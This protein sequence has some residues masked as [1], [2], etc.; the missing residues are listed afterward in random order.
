MP[1]DYK[2][3]TIR[4][5]EEMTNEKYIKSIFYYVQ[6]PYNKEKLSAKE[7]SGG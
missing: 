3:E 6:V 5:L 7:E 1:M 2:K 4:M